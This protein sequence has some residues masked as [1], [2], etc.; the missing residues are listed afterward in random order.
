M[1]GLEVQMVFTL[2]TFRWLGVQGSTGAL[3]PVV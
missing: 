1:L 2:R 3:E